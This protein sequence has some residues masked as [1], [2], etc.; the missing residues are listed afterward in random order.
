MMERWLKTL[1]PLL[2]LLAFVLLMTSDWYW[3]KPRGPHN[4]VALHIERV[5]TAVL[6][7]DWQEAQEA[8]RQLDTAWRFMITRLQFSVERDEIRG[9]S[10][11]LARL[12]GALQAGDKNGALVELAAAEEHW[13]DLGR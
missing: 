12:R 8:W 2:I 4:D 10:L 11:S 9:L 5:R 1:V 6:A 13:H 7:E 3:K